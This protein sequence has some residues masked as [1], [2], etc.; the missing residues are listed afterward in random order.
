MII[1]THTIRSALAVAEEVFAQDYVQQGVWCTCIKYSG[2]ELP[3]QIADISS[4]GEAVDCDCG[5]RDTVRQDAVHSFMDVSP[6]DHFTRN[7]VRYFSLDYEGRIVFNPDR[8]ADGHHRDLETALLLTVP[9]K[10]ASTYNM[11]AVRGLEDDGFDAAL[12]ALP[13]EPPPSAYKRFQRLVEDFHLQPVDVRHRQIH[14]DQASEADAEQDGDP[15]DGPAFK[16]R[17]WDRHVAPKRFRDVTLQELPPRWMMYVR[18][19]GSP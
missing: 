1:R 11:A 17:L 13:T 4:F 15:P 2:V 14:W 9:L 10:D 18:V 7:F 6:P 12:L 3:R 5:E 19:E 16:R 8:L